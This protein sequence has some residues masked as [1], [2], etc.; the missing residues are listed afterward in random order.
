VRDTT[1]VVELN[2]DVQLDTSEVEDI[3]G[4]SELCVR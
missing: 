2:D 1:R 3:C 4:G